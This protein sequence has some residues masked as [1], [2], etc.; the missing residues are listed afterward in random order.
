MPVFTTRES[1]TQILLE[2]VRKQRSVL[3]LGRGGIGKSALLEHAGG[4]LEFEML[5]VKLERVMPFAKFFRVVLNWL[6]A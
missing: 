2:H 5:V 1:E 3:I 4:T 6:S